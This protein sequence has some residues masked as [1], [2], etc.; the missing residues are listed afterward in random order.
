MSDHEGVEEIKVNAT[1]NGKDGTTHHE[2]QN[3]QKLFDGDFKEVFSYDVM[4]IIYSFHE[5]L[6]LLWLIHNLNLS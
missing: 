3:K 5:R 2:I 4:K 1:L 6:P